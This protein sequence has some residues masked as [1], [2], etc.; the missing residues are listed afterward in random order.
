MSEI[1]RLDFIMLTVFMLRAVLVASCLPADSYIFFRIPKI[2][3]YFYRLYPCNHKMTIRQ[4][5]FYS[6]I[7]AAV[8]VKV[9]CIDFLA[10]SWNLRCS[11]WTFLASLLLWTLGSR[12]DCTRSLIKVSLLLYLLSKVSRC[13]FIYCFRRLAM[14]LA[15]LSEALSTV[16]FMIQ[17]K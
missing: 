15:C 3:F 12:K 6:I 17:F 10:A 4:N 13:S 5:H 14:M 11:S 7:F 2:L 16:L 8:L 9:V 1:Y